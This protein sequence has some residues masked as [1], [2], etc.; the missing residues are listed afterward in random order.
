MPNYELPPDLAQTEILRVVV[1]ENLTEA[2]IDRLVCD[3][4]RPPFHRAS[5]RSLVLTP[6]R[7]CRWSLRNALRS[8]TAGCTRSPPSGCT[9][10]QGRAIRRRSLREKTA[11]RPRAHTRNRAKKKHVR[12]SGP[13]AGRCGRR[14][15]KRPHCTCRWALFSPCITM[16]LRAMP[17]G[18]KKNALFRRCGESGHV[19]HVATSIT[20]VVCLHRLGDHTGHC[21]IHAA[22]GCVDSHSIILKGYRIWCNGHHKLG[23]SVDK[24]IKKILQLESTSMYSICKCCRARY[25]LLV[26]RFH[27]LT[28]MSLYSISAD[29]SGMLFQEF[30]T[31]V[32]RTESSLRWFQGGVSVFPDRENSRPTSI[33][34]AN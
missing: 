2:L 12:A 1:R 15:S 14:V 33:D 13:G 18:G 19:A 5:Q 27:P 22:S 29:S 20:A 10:T 9:A 6:R 11:S 31:T 21:W 32:A 23:P 4:V 26:P 28:S 7:W 24:L 17:P 30:R 8:R 34:V 3:L 16:S 25:S